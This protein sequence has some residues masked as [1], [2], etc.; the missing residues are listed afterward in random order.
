MLIW[1]SNTGKDTVGR[2]GIYRKV[3][4]SDGCWKP[5]NLSQSESRVIALHTA[6]FTKAL[7][8]GWLHKV[9][10]HLEE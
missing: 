6:E 10:G 8:A 3:T 7:A 9:L 4:L 5:R 2:R 1:D